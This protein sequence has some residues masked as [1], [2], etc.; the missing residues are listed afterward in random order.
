MSSRACACLQP[1]SA[2]GAALHLYHP[3]RS[4]RGVAAY[5]RWVAIAICLFFILSAAQSGE[6]KPRVHKAAKIEQVDSMQKH[7][8]NG[9]GHTSAAAI[10]CAAVREWRRTCRAACSERCAFLETG[11]ARA[12]DNIG[13]MSVECVSYLIDPIRA[14]GGPLA[15]GLIYCRIHVGGGAVCCTAPGAPTCGPDLG[16]ASASG[17]S[18]SSASSA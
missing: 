2:A 7:A 1:A 18:R 12:P 4:L 3:I 6:N 14:C 5:A 10:T 15:V 16:A 8:L 13:R 9:T 11:G 17:Q